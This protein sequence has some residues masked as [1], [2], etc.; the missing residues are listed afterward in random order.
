VPSD[1]GAVVAAGSG[2]LISYLAYLQW[3]QEQPW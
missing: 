1:G 2:S 3:V